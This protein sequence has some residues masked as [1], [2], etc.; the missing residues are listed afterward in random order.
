M[1][2][3]ASMLEDI[4]AGEGLRICLAKSDDPVRIRRC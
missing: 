4:G 2:A 1:V 3:R